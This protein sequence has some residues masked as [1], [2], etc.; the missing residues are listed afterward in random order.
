MRDQD[1]GQT[2]RGPHRADIQGTNGQHAATE[3]SRGE[4]KTGGYAYGSGKAATD[5]QVD[6]GQSPPIYLV[7][8]LVGAGWRLHGRI[9]R[10]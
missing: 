10:Y 9:A 5:Q 7:D 8:D 3:C 4:L 1:R 6:V 2:H